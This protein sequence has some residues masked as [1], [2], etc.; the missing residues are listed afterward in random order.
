MNNKDLISLQKAVDL[1]KE[2]TGGGI[3]HAFLRIQLDSFPHLAYWREEA[4]GARHPAGVRRLRWRY[5]IKGRY[6][7]YGRGGIFHQGELD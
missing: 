6:L 1:Y 5:F 4:G 3:N 2:I 7:L